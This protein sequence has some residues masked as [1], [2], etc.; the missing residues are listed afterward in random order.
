[1]SIVV[2]LV[3]LSAVLSGVGGFV[4]GRFYE[5]STGDESAESS[6]SGP[7]PRS[8]LASAVEDKSDSAKG[9]ER[10]AR[11]CVR[12]ALRVVGR[13]SA[14]SSS[15]GEE[16]ARGEDPEHERLRSE[17]S[18]ILSL[19]EEKGLWSRGVGMKAQQLLAQLPPTDTA[20]LQE[21]LAEARQSGE[22]KVQVGAWVPRARN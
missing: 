9:E 22:V 18:R 11:L 6:S 8:S 3:M 15:G 16:A 17:L 7:E 21:R 10:I 2:R 12:E 13:R 4:M 1:M 14:G 19:V 5:R 20:A